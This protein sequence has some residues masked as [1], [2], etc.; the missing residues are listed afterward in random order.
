M[1][2]DAAKYVSDQLDIDKI[3]E[4]CNDNN[5]NNFVWNQTKKRRTATDKSPKVRIAVALDESFNFYYADNLEALR[6]KGAELV[7]FSPIH[8]RGLPRNVQGIILGGGFPEVL[9]DKLEKNRLMINSIKRHV[10]RGAVVYGECGGLMYLTRAI[11][12][13]KGRI[14]ARRMVGLVDADTVMTGKLTLNY[15]QAL[16]NSPLLGRVRLRGHEF[17]YSRLENIASDS[18]FAYC[19]SKGYG[20]T[21]SHDGFIINEHGLAAYMHL[22]FSNNKLADRIVEACVEYSH[23]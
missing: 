4:L 5:N 11:T 23:R 6:S 22:H 7:F 2:L 3:F 8:D 9:A 14:K 13:Y 12:C 10:Q 21:G 17:H 20:I 15:T 18:R 19:M 16:C 1:I